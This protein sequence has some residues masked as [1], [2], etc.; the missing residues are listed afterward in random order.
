MQTAW[1]F[2]SVSKHV[3]LH[4]G[5]PWAVG[6]LEVGEGGGP[7][8]VCGDLH[9]RSS[10]WALGVLEMG[11]RERVPIGQLGSELRCCKECALGV[12]KVDRE[13]IRKFW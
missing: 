4:V 7:A 10:A 3:L 9:A 2:L 6:V 13:N 5:A 8:M 11:T 1:D 12:L